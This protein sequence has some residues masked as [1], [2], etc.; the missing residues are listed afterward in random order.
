MPISADIQV[1]QFHK[2]QDGWM[3]LSGIMVIFFLV[4]SIGLAANLARTMRG[5]IR[6]QNSADNLAYSASI[7]IARGLN[8]IT[9]AQHMIGEIMAVSIIHSGFYGHFPQEHKIETKWLPEK[10]V[11]PGD[12]IK[13]YE[14][15]RAKLPS[16]NNPPPDQ[17]M[18]QSVQKRLEKTYRKQK[19]PKISNGAID[20]ADMQLALVVDITYK[21]QILGAFLWHIGY[22]RGIGQAM[23]GIAKEIQRYCNLE[24]EAL[25]AMEKA[26]EGT[27]EIQNISWELIKSIHSYEEL[28]VNTINAQCSGAKFP[29]E[30]FRTTQQTRYLYKSSVYDPYQKLPV[31]KEERIE[32]KLILDEKKTYYQ[33]EK[34]KQ[35]TQS[36]WVKA[37]SPWVQYNRY[38]FVNASKVFIFSQFSNWY[39]MRTGQYTLDLANHMKLGGEEGR[40]NPGIAQRIQPYLM[41]DT[42]G[43]D[44]N[45]HNPSRKQGWRLG[46][47]QRDQ[48]RLH[49]L[50]ATVGMVW[51]KQPVS[52]IKLF[53][54]DLKEM[55]SFSQAMVYAADEPD[56][57]KPNY[58]DM[59]D[60]KDKKDKE[61]LKNF[62]DTSGWDT[63]VWKNCV[64]HYTHEQGGIQH[65]NR[66]PV[67]RPNWQVKLVPASLAKEA[68]QQ[69]KTPSEWAKMAALSRKALAGH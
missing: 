35:I 52:R 48:R 41:E 50:F 37:A 7:P 62:Q 16:T 65:Q 44:K 56:K 36:Q 20:D 17:K 2:N 59:E 15:A 30:I 31:K 18:A 22:T 24:T 45:G 53:K 10:I 33:R 63:L 1:K 14:G 25:A 43:P 23:I 42:P 69:S 11:T 21:A 13:S 28:V 9:G 3:L 47:D 67:A 46:N 27:K 51:E 49:M 8:T 54:D 29:A 34:N 66:M 60:N 57:N 38:G 12:L 58:K 4:L 61:L 55:G 40:K 64:P 39:Q 19:K 26:A 6:A 68:L 5:K 32:R